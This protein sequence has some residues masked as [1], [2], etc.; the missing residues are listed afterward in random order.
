M[1]VTSIRPSCTPQA[2][3]CLSQAVAVAL[4]ALAFYVGANPAAAQ[5]TPVVSWAVAT[6]SVTETDSDATV[7]L[8]VNINP[9]L[10]TAS[11]VTINIGSESTATSNTD[12]TLPST[13]LKLPAQQTSV[14]FNITIVGDDIAESTE[15]IVLKLSGI[16]DAPYRITEDAATEISITDDETAGVTVDPT[17]LTVDEGSTGTYTLKLLSQP[18]GDVTVSA[19]SS[20]ASVATVSP[21]S[22]TFTPDNWHEAQTLTVSGVDDDDAEDGSATISHVVSGYGSVTTADPVQITVTDD[23]TPNVVVAPT[24]LTVDE[25]STQTY[26]LK[27][28]SQPG[29][30]VIVSASSSAEGV[31]TVAPESVTFT[32]DNWSE[33]QTLT[34]SGV[35]DNDADN[36]SATISHEV[37]GYGSITTA[38]PVEITVTDDETPNVLV[39]PTNLTVDEGSTQTYTLQLSSQPDGDVMV[40]ASSSAA[41]VATVS[42]ESVTFTP[43]NWH[44]AQT[45]TVSGVQDD[46]ANNGSA[47]ISHE[48]SGYGSITTADPVAVSVTD[49]ETPNVVVA[50]TSL[51]VDEGSTQTYTL[52][53][54]SQPDGD[55][56]VTA[57]SGA[58]SVATVFPESVTFTPDNW[59]ETQTLTVSGVQD[60]DANNGSATIS[61]E[62]SGYGSVTTADPVQITVTDDETSGVLVAPTSLTVDEGSTQT[63]TLQLSSQPDG[64][65]MVRATSSA[66]DVATVAPGSVTFTADNWNTAQTV[67]VTGVQDDD[68]ED[69]SATI[70][71]VVSGYGSVTTAD[72]VQITVTDDETPNVVVAPTS[73]TVDEGSTQTYTLKL[74]SQPG[75]TVIVSASSSAEGVA[76]VA[77]ESVTFTPDNWSETQTLTVSGVQDNDADNGSA[78]ISHEVS[79][80]GSIT[81]A[82]PVEITVTDDET[83]NVLV[84]PTNLTVDEGSTQT[85][86]LQL[87]S[88]PDGD[89]MVRASS[90]AAS[91]ATVSPESVTFTPDNWSETQTL[92]VS[93]VQDNDAD[94][95]S[96]TISHE[97][98]GYG[99]VTTADPVE[100]TVTDDETPNVLVAPTSLTLDEGSTQTY[101]LKLSSQPDGDVMV[102]ATSSA[103]D[104]A[105]V[106][107]ESVTFTADN[108][109]TA[110]TVTVTGVQDDDAEDGSATI[111]HEVSGYGSVTTADPVQITV[112]DDE[113]TGVLVAPTSLTL[114]E[115]STGTYTLK[116]SSQPIG[117]VMVST[118]SSAASVATVSPGTVTF[119]VDNWHEAQTLTVSG[120]QDDDANNGSATISHEVSGYGSITTADQVEITVTD[121]ETTGV[122]VDPTSLTVD[123]GSSKTYT[124]VLKSEPTV[125]VTVGVT[126]PTGT[127]VSVSP[128]SLTFTADDWN[129]AQTVTVSAAADDDAV[130]DDQVSITHSVSSTGDYSGETAESV[131]VSITETI[132]PVLSIENAS[133]AEDAGTLTFTVSLSVESSREK[134]RFR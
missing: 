109:N 134:K 2:G 45:L 106:A 124:V 37:S 116:L 39:A 26:T 14:S 38:D 85:Y 95:G 122:L 25:G 50:P 131:E 30:T 65:V 93:G 82:D 31:A 21:E 54:S 71:H 16:S 98:S 108:W 35:Q 28:S 3:D 29:G 51:T 97:V 132:V 33:T 53:L 111:S 115:G 107:P 104:V 58:A 67:T 44:E 69:G 43:D 12:Y 4:V 15:T 10:T 1:A 87:S 83:P 62:V 118:S 110:Q 130:V 48:V 99:S 90:S 56:N 84:A 24:S 114:D 59:S 46:D 72:P 32:P 88:Q 91:V 125:S 40:R 36:G 34:V 117:N 5:T 123:E 77:P 42:P 86:T 64:D 101:T 76:T 11:T 52:Q 112:T 75:G 27:L 89:V 19:S 61:H 100:I 81:T 94:N 92:T 57:S 8:T 133:A 128:T 113:T 22:V 60:D 80:Y 9:A 96:A 129:T 18:I 79:G 120:V 68:A 73:L 78:T 47:T 70:S 55:V 7:S 17:S 126:V 20:A 105:T 119:T 49:D 23:E 66:E 121:D 41:S 13:T 102:S 103:E 63:Y 127:D 6:Y 74:S